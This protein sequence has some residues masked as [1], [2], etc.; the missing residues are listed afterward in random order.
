LYQID[1]ILGVN[2]AILLL[3]G[4][5]FYVDDVAIMEAAY[6][7]KKCGRSHAEIVEVL[8]GERMLEALDF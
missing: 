1:K 8:E 5:N 4:R 2:P 7:L 6:V 3:S